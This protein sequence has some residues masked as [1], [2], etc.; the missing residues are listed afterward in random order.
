MAV[1]KSFLGEDEINAD[2]EITRDIF[3]RQ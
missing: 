2:T 3:I 1:E